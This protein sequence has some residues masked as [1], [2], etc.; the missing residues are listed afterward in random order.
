MNSSAVSQSSTASATA[1]MRSGSESSSS[2]AA[3]VSAVSVR[4]LRPFTT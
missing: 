3:T 4:G 1:E 2:F